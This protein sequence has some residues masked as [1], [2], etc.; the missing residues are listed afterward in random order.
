MPFSASDAKTHTKKATTAKQRRQWASVANSTRTKCLDSVIA[1]GVEEMDPKVE[2][3]T[4]EVE[5]TPD[6]I[7]KEGYYVDDAVE[8][9]WSGATSFADLEAERETIE[10]VADLRRTTADLMMMVDNAN[11]R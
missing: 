5:Q 6:A 1:K 9:I 4:T 10:T 8:R 11:S 3:T 7:L 2:E